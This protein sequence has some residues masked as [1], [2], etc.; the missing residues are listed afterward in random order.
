MEKVWELGRAMAPGLLQVRSS[1]SVVCVQQE[2]EGDA[3]HTS[4]GCLSVHYLMS[5]G[6]IGVVCMCSVHVCD[7]CGLC[8]YGM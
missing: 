2:G 8:Q 1:S 3:G 4:V 6:C 7:T 5:V